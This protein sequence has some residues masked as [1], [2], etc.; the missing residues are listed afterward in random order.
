[1]KTRI[2]SV[3]LLT[4]MLW[5]TA[6]W[7]VEDGLGTNHVQTL[8]AYDGIV[9]RDETKIT[10][11][12]DI[13]AST[14]TNQSIST[15]MLQD[16]AVT[17]EKIAGS[18]AG[19]GLTGGAGSALAVDPAL[20]LEIDLDGKLAVDATVVRTLTDFT[21]GGNIT[22]T[23]TITVPEP[24]DPAHAATQGYVDARVAGPVTAG[25][26]ANQ[27]LRW[28]GSAW[29]NTSGL[30]VD[31]D[32]NVV[33][34]DALNV[35]GLL[36]LGDDV[37]VAGDAAVVGTL[38]VDG[39]TTL[40]DT[41]VDGEL[42]VT[43][44]STLD[45]T[46]VDGTLS[47]TEAATFNDDVTVSGAATMEDTL[48]VS[49]RAKFDGAVATTPTGTTGSPIAVVAGTGIDN[50]S[51]SYVI[52]EGAGG[53]TVVSANPQITTTGAVPGQMITLQG[54][55]NADWVQLSNGDGLVL[56]GGISFTLRQGHLIQFIYDGSV[57]RE[58]FRTVPAP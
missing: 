38:Q 10:S 12:T 51:R 45:D 27:T 31:A 33:I 37:T 46:T 4:T 20:G 58:T 3:V 29:T 30:T 16:G 21:L 14:L 18:V 42:T 39:E 23:N 48:D 2:L 40:D 54:Q 13:S 8:R 26:G 15:L 53:P 7:A 44:A 19:D 49:G 36:T 1:M 35:T 43:G 11:W 41:T 22:F 50:I 17:S 24:T 25:T 47:V 55:S 6:A 34:G 9:L 5:G 56:A 52:I 32:N 57:W 28:D